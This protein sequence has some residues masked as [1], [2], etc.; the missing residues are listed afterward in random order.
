[1]VYNNGLQY[2]HSIQHQQIFLPNIMAIIFLN[3][4]HSLKMEKKDFIILFLYNW[5]GLKYVLRLIFSKKNQ[6][7]TTSQTF[8]SFIHL[9]QLNRLQIFLRS[10]ILNKKKSNENQVILYKILWLIDAIKNMYLGPT[11]FFCL[12]FQLHKP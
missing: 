1:M 2:K 5:P 12:K 6:F 3:Y 8:L 9:L 10:F 4:D 7:L 11:Q